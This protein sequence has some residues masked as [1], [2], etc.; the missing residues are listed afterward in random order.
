MA[1]NGDP[2]SQGK[3]GASLFVTVQGLDQTLR[4]FD[5]LSAELKK[6]ANGE[7][8]A[9]SKAIAADLIPV[10]NRTAAASPAPQAVAVAGT[11]RAKSDRRVTVTI[12]TVNPKFRNH[13]W[14][15]PGVKRKVTTKKSDRVSVA[16]GSNYGPRGGHRQGRGW[17]ANFYDVARDPGGLFVEPAVAR[18]VNAAKSAYER[19]LA[20]I[21][22]KYGL[23]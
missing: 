7:L 6:K 14:T 17:G 20:T 4:Q 16:F 5:R 15:V 19:A 1:W 18:S 3:N 22:R 13:P 23:I 2:R 10:I 21:L 8:R 12:G 9:A 11:A